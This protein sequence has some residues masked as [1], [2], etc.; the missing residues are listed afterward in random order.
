MKRHITPDTSASPRVPAAPA[1]GGPDAPAGPRAWLPGFLLL[2]LIWGASFLFI[3]VAIRELHPVY[4]TLFRVAAGALTV[5]VVLKATG[6]RLPRDL[7]TWGH[8]TFVGVFGVAIPFTLFG[9]GEQHVSSVLAGIWNATTPLVAL[10][11]AVLV[12]R[13]E[14]LTAR[15]LVGMVLGFAGVLLVLGVWRG[16]GGS[17]LVGQ[18]LCF[19]A[20]VCYGVIIGYQRRYLTGVPGGS[21]AVP[22]GNLITA[23]VLLA[24]VAPFVAGP[25]PAPGDLSLPVVASVLALGALGTGLAFV[26]HFRVITVA[27]A[28]TGASVTYLLPV[29]AT[30]L[31]VLVLGEHIDWNQ[32]VGGVVVL[33]G[34]AISQGM[35]TARRRAAAVPG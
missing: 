23:T 30:L 17:A 2:A 31:G 11:L 7:R 25:P 29:V 1:A 16:V 35:V 14:R 10:P 33:L 18:L 12:Y 9:Y 5:L 24:V 15:R 34:V 8:M 13:T 26:L 19:G 4:V 6:G 21:V 20:A 27:G 22:A 3:E 32:P 28:S